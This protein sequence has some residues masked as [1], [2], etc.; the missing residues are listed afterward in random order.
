M[1]TL[2]EPDKKPEQQQQDAAVRQQSPDNDQSN[3]AA[4]SKV[5][6]ISSNVVYQQYIKGGPTDVV[7]ASPELSPEALKT[8]VAL[9]LSEL[10]VANGSM[11]ELIDEIAHTANQRV[12]PGENNPA[13][14]IAQ[15]LW[16]EIATNGVSRDKVSV[17]FSR[18]QNIEGSLYIETP[19]SR[20]ADNT[21]VRYRWQG[22]ASPQDI[23]TDG[24]SS[25]FAAHKDQYVSASRVEG[26]E[27]GVRVRSEH[28]DR[29][30]ARVEAERE[31]AELDYQTAIELANSRSGAVARVID[32]LLGREVPEPVKREV[33]DAP[34]HGVYG[35]NDPRLDIEDCKPLAETAARV[36]RTIESG[37]DL[38]RTRWNERKSES[39]FTSG[40]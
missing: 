3:T 27:L 19:E 38:I 8:A 32:S 39:P 35:L 15:K 30:S 17:S 24:T 23:Y 36:A 13:K 2:P 25:Y 21:A 37:V 4:T 18:A 11:T 33:A 31:Q 22:G 7:P 9:S 26:K 5:L 28:E 6:D 10:R 34:E 16:E 12:K 40:I 1:N 29:I 20:R 14:V